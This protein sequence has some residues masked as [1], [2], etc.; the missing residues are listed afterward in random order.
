M[1]K[2]DHDT[3]VNIKQLLRFVT[4]NEPL[5]DIYAGQFVDGTQAV[6]HDTSSKWYMQDQYPR[7]KLPDYANGPG[8][9]LGQ[10]ALSFMY[11]HRH[12]LP[13]YR[14]DDAGIG[15]W[16][17]G[18]DSLNRVQMEADIYEWKLSESSVFISP[19]AKEEMLPLMTRRDVI[20]RRCKEVHLCH[21]APYT[22]DW[23]SFAHKEYQDITKTRK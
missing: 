4:A 17:Q 7:D 1:F 12:T 15:I 18:V 10:K 22:P 13:P 23:A 20:L 8:I 19:V 6:V 3:Y 5:D 16:L 2:V 21:N 14:V 9:L 11:K